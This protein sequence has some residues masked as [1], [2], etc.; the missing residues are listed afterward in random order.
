MLSYAGLHAFEYTNEGTLK[1]VDIDHLI[2]THM[3]YTRIC[4]DERG[5]YGCLPT[6]WHILFSLIIR[7]L[8]IIFCRS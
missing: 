3:M 1:K 5:I 7:T 8:T 2:D 6:I 4:K